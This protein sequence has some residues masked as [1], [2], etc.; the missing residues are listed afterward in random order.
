MRASS[1]SHPTDWNSN[2]YEAKHAFV[3]KAADS[4]LE[5]LDAQPGERI[6]DLG[7]GTG[8]LTAKIAAK[9]SDVIGLDHSQTMLDQA[10]ATFPQLRFERGDAR[11]VS[12]DL[13]FDAV[14]SNATL[15]WVK[16]PEQ[17]AAC[18]AQALRLGGR[19]VAEFGGR[20]N[21]RTIESAIQ[22][23]AARMGQPLT[24]SLW[25]YPSIAEYAAVLEQAGLEV[26]FA[27]LFD[28][29]TPLSGEEG[30]RNWIK[31]FCGGVL[32]SL[33]SQQ[34]EDFLSQAEVL[35]RANLFRD[36]CWIADY[37]R[38]RVIAIRGHD[39]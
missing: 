25:Y 22:T 18:I 35:T 37:R 26:T 31:M 8:H 19:F 4:L 28:R 36:D 13:P 20:G 39:E 17:A 14:F 30:L 2:L 24:E 5:L 11:D 16:P 3:W 34:Q 21:V 7:C 15:H 27:T 10:R 38:L 12:F 29:P 33:S 23:V 1:L 6:L 32:G 9:G